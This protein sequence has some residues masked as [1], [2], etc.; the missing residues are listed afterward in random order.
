M[1]SAIKDKNNSAKIVGHLINGEI[2]Q[3]HPSVLQENIIIKESGW[4]SPHPAE[5]GHYL[6][7]VH[8]NY[9]KYLEKSKRQ[10]YH[11]RNNFSFDKMKERVGDLFN[12]NIPNFPSQI[13]LNL[14]NLKSKSKL[15]Q[16]EKN[17]LPELKPVENE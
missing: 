13:K 7:D 5:I 14:P 8:K 17:K 9:K 4:F 11:S 10:G 16:I 12:I 1:V 3:V 15:P 6:V 2:K